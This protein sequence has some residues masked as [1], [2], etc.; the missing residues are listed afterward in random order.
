ME[1]AEKK[2]S[3]VLTVKA[4]AEWLNDKAREYP[5]VI[6]P[7]IILDVGRA[8]TYDCYVD[9]SQASTSFPYDYY[10]YAGYSSLGKTRTYIKFDLPELPDKCSI[11]TNASIHFWQYSVDLGDG[12][13]GFLNIHNVTG[14]WENDRTVTWNAQP[15]FDSTVVDYCELK[16]GFGAEYV[17]DIT[18]SVKA[19]YEGSANYGLMLKSSDEAKTKR[20]QLFSA[21]NT[22]NNAYPVIQL[23]Y[24]NNKGIESYWSYSSYSNGTGGTGYVN[25]YTGNLVYEIPLVSS[26]SEIMPLSLTAVFNSY[27]ANEKYC[28]G[29][30]GSSKTTFGR[31]FRLNIQET[32]LPSSAYGLTG[33][34]ASNYPYVYT[35]EDGTEHYIQK[36]TEDGATVYKDEDGLN[37]TLEIGGECSYRIK[38]KLGNIK[39]FNSRGN[40]FKIT[41]ADKKILLVLK[42]IYILRR[43]TAVRVLRKKQKYPTLLTVR[44]INLL[45]NI[46]KTATVFP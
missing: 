17:F 23:T 18:K 34:A 19:W 21:E 24:R 40:L 14:T 11:I 13:T 27:C 39:W 46:S 35:D 38:D 9:N 6:D 44:D 16:S 28:A 10:L 4:S 37:L 29:K 20:T 43:Q 36:I 2:G 15:D 3:Y 7:T 45:L 32:V 26:I 8:K 12:S 22:G 30:N 5:V 25:D 41:D 1:I 42:Y 31:G 33:A